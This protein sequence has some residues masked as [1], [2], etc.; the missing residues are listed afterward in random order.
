M[1]GTLDDDRIGMAVIIRSGHE[2]R[3]KSSFLPFF[4][5]EEFKGTFAVSTCNMLMA[6]KFDFSLGSGIDD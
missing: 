3:F 6:K 1:S 2:H 4:F 5:Y